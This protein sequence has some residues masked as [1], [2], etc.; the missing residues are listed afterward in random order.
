MCLPA[1]TVVINTET[2]QLITTNQE[3][4]QTQLFDE[5]LHQEIVQPLPYRT[6][7]LDQPR[8]EKLITTPTVL[9]ETTSEPLE[10][11][12][13]LQSDDHA[14]LVVETEEITTEL[15]TD[16]ADKP[17]QIKRIVRK[18]VK[19]KPTEKIQLKPTTRS[20]IHSEQINQQVNLESISRKQPLKPKANDIFHNSQVTEFVS[21]EDHTNLVISQNEDQKSIQT[22]QDISDSKFLLADYDESFKTIQQVQKGE[23]HKINEVKNLVPDYVEPEQSVSYPKSDE[24]SD[25]QFIHIVNEEINASKTGMDSKS[26]DDRPVTEQK[27]TFDLQSNIKSDFPDIKKIYPVPIK[28]ISKVATNEPIAETVQAP[29][30]KTIIEP[31]HEEIIQRPISPLEQEHVVQSEVV[32]DTPVIKQDSVPSSPSSKRKII[33]KKIIVKKPKA[34]LEQ[35]PEQVKFKTPKQREI[36]PDDEP[37]K[38]TLKPLTITPTPIPELKPIQSAPVEKAIEYKQIIIPERE[39]IILET[40]LPYEEPS[41]IKKQQ[42]PEPSHKETIIS[43]PET[44]IESK[45]IQRKVSK[46]VLPDEPVPEPI[47]FK[48]KQR[49]LGPEPEPE[50]VKLKPIPQKP[51]SEPDIEPVLLKPIPKPDKIVPLPETDTPKLKLPLKSPKP[52]AEAEP[53]IVE[54]YDPSTKIDKPCKNVDSTKTMPLKKTVEPEL[55][56]IKAKPKQKR[57][58]PDAELESIK[59]KP[60]QKPAEPIPEPEPIKL[61]PIPKSDAPKPKPEIMSLK[62]RQKSPEPIPEPEPIELKPYHKTAELKPDLEPVPLKPIPKTVELVPQQ[63]PIKLKPVTKPVE[64]VQE[65]ESVILKPIRRIDKPEPEPESVSL[66]PFKKTPKPVPIPEPEPESLKFKKVQK[67]KP[68]P[69]E[70]EPLHLKPIQKLSKTIP[71][72]EPIKLK[73]VRKS[74]PEPIPELRPVSLKPIKKSPELVDEPKPIQLKPTDKLIVQHEAKPEKPVLKPVKHI[75]TKPEP[76][77]EIVTLKPI[78][79]PSLPEHVPQPVTPKIVTGKPVQ[80]L[81]QHE[82]EQILVDQA[83]ETKSIKQNDVEQITKAIIS[84]VDTKTDIITETNFV[85]YINVPDIP[86]KLHIESF[87]ENISLETVPHI[88]TEDKK[89]TLISELKPTEPRV[90]VQQSEE[91]L[92]EQS[93]PASPQHFTQSTAKQIIQQDVFLSSQQTQHIQLVQQSTEQHHYEDTQEQINII[94]E[95][96][97]VT[98]TVTRQEVPR[99]VIEINRTVFEVSP[100]S[101]PLQEQETQFSQQEVSIQDITITQEVRKFDQV[102]TEKPQ[103]LMRETQNISLDQPENLQIVHQVIEEKPQIG[104]VYKTLDTAKISQPILQES[105]KTK[106]IIKKVKKIVKKPKTETV[107][108]VSEHIVEEAKVQEEPVVEEL[109][110]K[111][112][113]PEQLPV[114]EDVKV[115]KKQVDVKVDQKIE[116]IAVEQKQDTVIVEQT[117]DT[118]VVEQKQ[119][120]VL[121]EQ[122]LTFVEQKRETVQFKQQQEM[123]QVEQMRSAVKIEEKVEAVSVQQKKVAKKVKKIVV[124]QEQVIEQREQQQQVETREIVEHEEVPRK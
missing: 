70:T 121:D 84:N 105:P 108:T 98:Q 51:K 38:V 29:T 80:L 65:P 21:I 97:H 75:E 52:K 124:N 20:Q 119:K 96:E 64:Q 1:E 39:E 78:E 123:V 67:P 60:R 17:K 83:L 53:E 16:I 12:E 99:E 19:T 120:T 22:I 49:P 69:E 82:I 118:V 95:V 55:E 74:E 43:I 94:P 57:T 32:L 47:K 73:P 122:K 71:E 8:T 63:Q 59:L 113:Q 110:E 28:P 23:G 66:K 48:I 37:E 90:V 87:V 2:S 30:K 85:K 103:M 61:K 36:K 111:I 54:P 107:V 42:S 106:T 35:G 46:K 5:Q 45:P 31:Q 112:P 89:I 34:E 33:R 11:N 3:T 9:A 50:E 7:S 4:P 114:I 92:L 62:P 72:T 79:K 25:S 81:P 24:V 68:L 76:E 100:Q 101:T 104:E 26:I 58:E 86:I 91:Q 88:V 77:P 44:M 27:Y 14:N 15:P 10:Q 115:L 56:Q 13:T 40:Y 109:V 102:T 93:I 41:T 116:T 117:Q 18:I 6:Q